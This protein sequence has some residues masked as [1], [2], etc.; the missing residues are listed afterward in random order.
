MLDKAALMIIAWN[1]FVMGKS[2]G[3]LKWQN[4][5]PFPKIV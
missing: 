1:H 2:L 5:S 4:D 3:Q